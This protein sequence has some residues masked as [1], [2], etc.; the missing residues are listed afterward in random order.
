MFSEN[1]SQ[2][3][4]GIIFLIVRV[5]SGALNYSFSYAAMRTGLL[6]YLSYA[7]TIIPEINI[8]L[9]CVIQADVPGLISVVSGLFAP[10]SQT[11]NW[12]RQMA[13]P[14]ESSSAGGF[15]FLPAN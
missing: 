7:Y 4:F 11:P 12:L 9:F 8:V 10:S 14:L 1:T 2:F 3:V 6:G 13:A 15:V 5:S